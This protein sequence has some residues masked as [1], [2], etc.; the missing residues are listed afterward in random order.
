DAAGAVRASRIAAMPTPRRPWRVEPLR[1]AIAV[2]ISTGSRR[3]SRDA[4]WEILSRRPLLSP[5]DRDCSTS[6]MKRTAHGNGGSGLA[7]AG[8]EPCECRSGLVERPPQP[9]EQ[10]RERGM[11]N[12]VR[13]LRL[14]SRSPAPVDF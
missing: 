12:L 7:H 5:T 9:D 1:N 13:V 8:P 6:S 14:L 2:S 4:R 3:V 11:T 10:R